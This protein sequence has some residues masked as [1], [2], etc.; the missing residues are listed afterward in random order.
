MEDCILQ[1]CSWGKGKASKAY[2][3]KGLS[4][5]EREMVITELAK[6]SDQYNCKTDH[7]HILYDVSRAV[8]VSFEYCSHSC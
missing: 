5:I 7:K 8:L 3:A 6:V 2:W 1:P 4:I